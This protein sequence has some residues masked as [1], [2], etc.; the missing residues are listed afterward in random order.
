[1]NPRRWLIVAILS[2]SLGPVPLI[3][4]TAGTVSVPIA[5]TVFG[6]PE[7]VFFSGTAR[8]TVRPAQADVAAVPRVVVSIDL[9]DLSGKGLTTGTVYSAGGQ[10]N[11]TRPLVAGDVIQATIPFFVRGS[12]PTA[13][14]R[15]A[16]ASFSFD[17]DI[18][19]GALTSARASLA[20]PAPAN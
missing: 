16:V 13:P 6:L 15:T 11:L 14:G 7:S 3:A 12:G 9:G 17:Y 18:A 1:M 20:A 4:Q 8:I 5:G 10:F 19:T 2:L